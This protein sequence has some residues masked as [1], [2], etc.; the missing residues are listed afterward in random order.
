MDCE[1][2]EKQFEMAASMEILD[3]GGDFYAPST[4]LEGF[5]GFDFATNVRDPRL[6][7]VINAAVPPAI[8]T[9][10]LPI[11]RRIRT[12]ME[13]SGL[14]FTSLIV[15]YKVPHFVQQ[16]GDFW[17]DFGQRP[18]YRFTTRKLQHRRLLKLED[19]CAGRAVVAYVS[20][21]FARFEELRDHGR[22]EDVVEHSV[23]VPPRY[24]GPKHSSYVYQHRPDQAFLNAGR[25]ESRFETWD[26]ELEAM[27]T[28]PGA[29]PMRAHVRQLSQAVSSI[30]DWQEELETVG[31]WGESLRDA[32]PDV[33]PGLRQD[34]VDLMVVGNTLRIHGCNWVLVGHERS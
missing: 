30:K 5:C 21:L 17:D 4:F 12:G 11:G 26:A 33:D 28:M 32:F 7:S 20:P 14:K 18:Y 22:R 13:L 6:W 24:I 3:S 25:D 19:A 31:A 8:V 34:I 23:F 15:Q 2:S 1:F 9:G 27:T 29:Q 10:T 16:D